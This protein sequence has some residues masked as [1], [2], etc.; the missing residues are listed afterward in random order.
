M[1]PLPA[2]PLN[3]GAAPILSAQTQLYHQTQIK[4][5]SNLAL[6]QQHRISLASVVPALP[7]NH[8]V[9]Q[10][11]AA[12]QGGFVYSTGIIST[13]QQSLP[14]VE[15][16]GAGIKR[17]NSAP[18]LWKLL[19]AEQQQQMLRQQQ[20][21]EQQ[22]MLQQQQLQQMALQASP[23]L[24]SLGPEQQQHQQQI[25]QQHQLQQQQEM[26]Q[27]HNLQQQQHW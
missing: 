27:K 2:V 16:S 23:E 6:A 22:Q 7:V 11:A 20:Q 18:D 13:G 26:L 12:L 17:R 5:Q 4:A 21:Q 10:P 9:L 15:S 1:V 24:Q 14:M 8:P 25:L 19:V 3:A